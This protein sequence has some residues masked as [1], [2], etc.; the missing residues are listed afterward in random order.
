MKS[1][2]PLLIKNVK[3]GESSLEV[4]TPFSGNVI[5]TFETANHDVV[6]LALSTADE[7]FKDRS[8]WLTVERRL[9][10]L[11]KTVL[12]ME[13]RFEQL[14]REAAAEGGKPLQ[15][16]RVE[17][18]R[19]IDGVR[20]SIECLRSDGGREI[21]MNKNLASINRLAFTTFEP[22]GPVVA[23]SAF[24]HPLN[25]IVHQVVPAIAAGN[26]VIVKPAEDTPISCYNFINILHEAGLPK[27]WC[28]SL[29][30]HDIDVATSLVTDSR[31]GFFSFI[32]SSRIGW[33]LRSKLAA[34]TRCA[35]EHG[36]AA[37]VIL[38]EDA[39]LDKAIPLL[40]KG[41]FYHAGQV[42]VS[43]Q[44]V[45]C[46]KNIAKKVATRLAAY[47]EKMKVGDPLDEET[48]IGPLIRTRE[49]NR[50]HE[51]VIEAGKSGAKI[52]SGGNP[53]SESCYSPTVIFNPPQEVQVSRLEIFGPVVCIYSYSNID[54]AIKQ[55]NS[56][57][58]AFQS[59][60]FTQDLDKALYISQRLNASAVMINDHTAF[61]TDWMPF[62]GLKES[63]LGT[64]GI[65]YTFHEM[66]TEKMT[67]FN[68]NS[69]LS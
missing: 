31:V 2:Y 1:H 33:M 49:V 52:Y 57:P 23:V 50:I 61:R 67:V 55:A 19:A 39:N 69:I 34:G 22:I 40:A 3:H 63:G 59:A 43:V 54:S 60:V 65:P 68:S 32:G 26:P 36:G 11:N 47:V 28:Q 25:L 44:R 64:G 46:H 12:I 18:D 10:I 66:Q 58:L 42:C 38:T 20:T 17:V 41:G 8:R 9:S 48:E 30:V 4:R 27:A 62:A 7:L 51:W 14:A 29:I 35:L 56:L 37:P 6:E 5:A 15:D 45:F 13:E 53:L 16:S 21:P 24:N